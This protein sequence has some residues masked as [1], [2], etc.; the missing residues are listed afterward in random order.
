LFYLSRC[1]VVKDEEQ[2][3]GRAKQGL[4]THL[5]TNSIMRGSPPMTILIIFCYAWR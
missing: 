3:E 4:Q 1:D 2:F 5:E